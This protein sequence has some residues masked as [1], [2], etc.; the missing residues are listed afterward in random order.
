LVHKPWE[1]G[2]TLSTKD[3]WIIFTKLGISKLI[4]SK[5]NAKC[6]QKCWLFGKIADFFISS[7]TLAKIFAKISAIF[8]KKFSRKAKINFCE[9]FAE[10]RKLKYCFKTRWWWYWCKDM[11]H[12]PHFLSQRI[13]LKFFKFGCKETPLKSRLE[14][15]H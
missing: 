11:L 3:M 6:V 4:F 2:L 14:F 10:M 12:F 7:K 5:L 9:N 15:S 1:F 8:V 13:Q